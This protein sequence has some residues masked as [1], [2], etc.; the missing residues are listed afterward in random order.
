MR[1]SVWTAVFLGVFGKFLILQANATIDASLQMQLGNPSGALADTNNHAHYL[2]QRTVEA[3]DYSDNLGGPVWASWDLTTNDFGTVTRSTTY[4]TDTNLPANFYRVTTTDYNGV[5]TNLFNRGHLCPSD[6]RRDTRQDN[7]TLF[8]MSNIMPQSAANNQGVWGNFEDYCRSLTTN[9]EL[10]IICGPS[11]FGARTIPSGKAYIGSNTWKVVVC[12]PLGGGTA[13]SR[14]TAATRVIAVSIPNV[15]NGLSS[16]W[17]TYVTSPKKIEQDT[18]FTFFT[19]LPA[20][21]AAV[22]RAEIDGAPTFSAFTLTN[23]QFRFMVNGWGGSN[24]VVQAATN[25]A[26]PNWISLTTNAAPFLFIQT[27]ASSFGQRFYRAKIG[28]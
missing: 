9:S 25:L 6:D 19:A 24:Y 20:D 1:R 10:L 28:P 11:G 21:V 26:T 4:V 15:T 5:G 8:F 23:N 27:N 12:V 17:Q 18:G 7:D 14:I 16:A 3:I 2:I 13:L 22:F